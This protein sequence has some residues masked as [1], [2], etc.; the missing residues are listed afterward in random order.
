M[1][2]RATKN[3][4]KN[5]PKSSVAGST[6]GNAVPVFSVRAMA[7]GNSVFYFGLIYSQI[8]LGN[9]YGAWEKYSS[10]PK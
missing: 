8:A 5:L 6:P 7:I 1:L 3:R 2:T 4:D 10:K 9:K